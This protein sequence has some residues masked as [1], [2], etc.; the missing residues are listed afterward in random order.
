MKKIL[1][2]VSQDDP[3][4]GHS[5][6]RQTGVSSSG[7]VAMVWGDSW[8]V[9]SLISTILEGDTSCRP[10]YSLPGGRTAVRLMGQGTNQLLGKGFCEQTG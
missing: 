9:S 10:G 7:I 8:R 1:N 6:G 4:E 5:K 2:R 3:G